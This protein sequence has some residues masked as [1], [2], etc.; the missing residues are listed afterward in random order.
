M[1]SSASTPG[2]L[3]QRDQ[4]IGRDWR[5]V[6][7][8]TPSCWVSRCSIAIS[9]SPWD[10]MP[11]F[12][13]ALPIGG[14]LAQYRFEHPK[15]SAARLVDSSHLRYRDQP[16]ISRKQLPMTRA[17]N[18]TIS[19][20]FTYPQPISESDVRYTSLHRRCVPRLG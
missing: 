20:C 17:V 15:L 12:K 13:P 16:S 11:T 5:R 9:A 18:P 3:G 2:E 6:V 8:A 14:F 4:P 7:Q 10:P 1:T 19:T